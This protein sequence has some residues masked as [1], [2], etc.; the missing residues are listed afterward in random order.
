VCTDRETLYI[1]Q[2]LNLLR[3]GDERP[4]SCGLAKGAVELCPA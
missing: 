2:P 1:Y 3:K 4:L